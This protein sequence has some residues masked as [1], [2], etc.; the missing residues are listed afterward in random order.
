MIEAEV[1]TDKDL[2]IAREKDVLILGVNLEVTS[3]KED[4]TDV[5]IIIEIEVR[6]NNQGSEVSL[7]L[8]DIELHQDLA[9]IMIHALVVDSLAILPILTWEG[10]LCRQSETQGRKSL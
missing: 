7:N 10:H 9:E 1:I 3:T 5:K 8:Q 4:N 6:A 2:M